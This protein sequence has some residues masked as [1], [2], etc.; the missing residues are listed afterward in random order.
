[1]TKTQC[2][3]LIVNSHVHCQRQFSQKFIKFRWLLA[4][5]EIK[6]C[7]GQLKLTTNKLRK[8]QNFWLE[9][10]F[11]IIASHCLKRHFGLLLNSLFVSI[12][13]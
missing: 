13:H 4:K 2:G 7:L 5:I 3:F 10:R 12:K 8:R 6:V 9:T 11:S 1:M